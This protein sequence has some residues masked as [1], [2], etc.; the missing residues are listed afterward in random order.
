MP[1]VTELSKPN[2]EPI[3]TTHS[4]TLALCESPIFTVG[5][6]LPSIL[7]SATSLCL[8]APTTFALYSRRSVRRTITSSAWSTTSALVRM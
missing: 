5:R 6:F 7:M 3:A 8:S 2:G 4:P 1:A